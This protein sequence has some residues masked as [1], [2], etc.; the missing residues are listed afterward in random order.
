M[1]RPIIRFEHPLVEGE[2]FR[3]LSVREGKGV[4]R[5]QLIQ[6]FRFIYAHD[7]LRDG[8][9]EVSFRDEHGREWMHMTGRTK[10]ISNGYSWNGNSPKRGVRFLGCDLWFGTPD[11]HPGTLEA[12]LGHDPDFQF[13]HTEHFPFTWTECN[14]HYLI[15]CRSRG[16]K[17]ANAFHGALAD[18]SKGGWDA[19]ANHP[20]HSV[21][22]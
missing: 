8:L 19:A 4:Y 14:Q 15:I 12:S 11:Y 21:A 20:V 3:R 9:H 2:N 18:F 7:I 17:L 5:F 6:D 16:F 10:T 1:N 13:S 22:L